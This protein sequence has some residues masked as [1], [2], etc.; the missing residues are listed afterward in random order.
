MRKYNEL[1]TRNKEMVSSTNQRIFLLLN[2][3]ELSLD[4]F[5]KRDTLYKKKKNHEKQKAYINQRINIFVKF[6]KL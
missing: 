5:Q 6:S 1:K 3:L 2:N 4:I